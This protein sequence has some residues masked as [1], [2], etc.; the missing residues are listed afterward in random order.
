MAFYIYR[1]PEGYWRWY[2]LGAHHRRVA[3]SGEG[4]FTVQECRDAIELVKGSGSAPVH[5]V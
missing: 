5:K 1:D 3:E 4:Y 2:L